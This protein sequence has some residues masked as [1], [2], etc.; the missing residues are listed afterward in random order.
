MQWHNFNKFNRVLCIIVGIKGVQMCL[1]LRIIRLH[2][3]KKIYR[4][5][6]IKTGTASAA[7]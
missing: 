1:F 7:K 3:Q 6:Y 2:K 5:Y 4:L